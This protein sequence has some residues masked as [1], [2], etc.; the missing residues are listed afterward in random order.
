[1]TPLDA[2]LSVNADDSLCDPLGPH[3]LA[4]PDDDPDAVLERRLR[5]LRMD[6]PQET[7]SDPEADQSYAFE[8]KA[9]QLKL[10]HEIAEHGWVT[11]QTQTELALDPVESVRMIRA[12]VVYNMTVYWK[13]REIPY[14]IERLID[15]V[16]ILD[17]DAVGALESYPA[18]VQRV[19]D[20]GLPGDEMGLA[21]QALATMVSGVSPGVFTCL[22]HL[23]DGAR[24][25][26]D[27]INRSIIYEGMDGLCTMLSRTNDPQER[28]EVRVQLE[29][30][31]DALVESQK[32]DPSNDVR[33]IIAQIE[34][35]IDESNAALNRAKERRAKKKAAKAQ[36]K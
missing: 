30:M 29:A 11:E 18:M 17:P 33:V 12:L 32:D 22:R 34:T 25:E 21:M 23:N 31:R 16:N 6:L 28:N 5:A 10:G 27:S 36:I 35:A 9:L 14:I 2:D 24:S 26:S 8:L 20:Q 1:M 19:I 15:A 4:V 7:V 13:R 3:D